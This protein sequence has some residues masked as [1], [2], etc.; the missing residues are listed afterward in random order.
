MR[1]GLRTARLVYKALLYCTRRSDVRHDEDE[2]FGD[3]YFIVRLQQ[4]PEILFEIK[5]RCIFTPL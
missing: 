2:N 3:N 5:T 1:C 4:E